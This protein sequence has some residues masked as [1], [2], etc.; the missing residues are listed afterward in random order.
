[1]KWCLFVNTII[2]VQK[3]YIFVWSKTKIFKI[4]L[5]IGS[6]LIYLSGSNCLR[7][8]D[9]LRF[10]VQGSFHI[11]TIN[12]R[13]RHGFESFFEELSMKIFWPTVFKIFEFLGLSK[14]LNIRARALSQASF[15]RR[16]I[17]FWDFK[18]LDFKIIS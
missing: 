15:K 14:S 11:E 2:S 8:T 16:W 17:W 12:S 1:M 13:W 18:K 3:I 5:S 4:N 7:Q 10:I 6:Y 9:H